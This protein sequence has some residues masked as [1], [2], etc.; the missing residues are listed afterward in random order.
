MKKTYLY[1]ALAII[2]LAIG[3]TALWHEN[4]AKASQAVGNAGGWSGGRPPAGQMD[5]M[6]MEGGSGGQAPGGKKGGM[7]MKPMTPPEVTAEQTAQ[8]AAGAADHKPTTLTFTV[9]GGMFYFV[10]NVIK[11]KKG[12]TVKIV[13][14]NDGGHHDFNL[15]EFGFKIAASDGGTTSTQQFV[16]DKVGSFEYFCSIGSHRKFGQKGTLVVE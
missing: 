4:R 12:D 15:D 6:K 14:V 9:H 16:A 2:A 8:L 3:G 13:Y 11:V 7:M 5:G 1:G 10:P